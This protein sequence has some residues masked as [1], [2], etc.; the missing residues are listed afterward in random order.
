MG[1]FD[2]LFGQSSASAN[3][4]P[5]RFGRYTDSYK[6]EMQYQAWDR[7]LAAFERD[8]FMTSYRE[9]FVYL[10]DGA[11]NNVQ[12]KE[13]GNRIDFEILQ[14]SKKV[15]G[16]ATPERFKA[17]APVAKASALNIGFMRRMVEHNFDLKFG[18]YAL[19]PDN[20]V[21]LVFDTYS[22]DGSPFKLYYALKEIATHAD[23]QDDL[24]LDEF[25]ML[26]PI[27]TEH[28]DELPEVEKEAK[29]RF[30]RE[31][32]Q[33]TFEYIDSNH[34]DAIQYPGGIAYLLLHLCYKLDYLTKPEGFM[35]E[36]LER[37]HRNYF[38][39]D[40]RNMAQKN[41]FMRKEFQKLLDRPKS[42]FFKEMYKAPS[43]FGITTPVN[44]DKIIAFID[45]ELNN[46]DWYRDQKY[47]DVA[48]AIPGYIAGYSV[49]N[50]AGP[51]PVQ[52]M[53]HLFFQ[54]TEAAYFEQLGFTP[55]LFDKE[56]GAFDQRAIKRSLQ[57]IEESNREKFPKLDIDAGKLVFTNLP[58]FAKSYLL[59]IRN[60]KLA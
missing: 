3:Q 29:Y 42:D 60:L 24:L 41:Q 20:E 38:A 55:V 51:R 15:T 35:M 49:F 43:T 34:L 31:E 28:T 36:A 8:D 56:K 22:L 6:D 19:S 26:T 11:E 7:A 40:N 47:F 58:D 44:L 39:N 45:S 5:V 37:M 18:R 10:R 30:I 27:Q 54:V 2:R 23:K 46:M 9:F 52:Q 13:F 32:I 21:V 48:L 25:D 4:P 1:L 33:R 57:Q 53:F 14:G 12:T 59:L 50:Y 16:F 17:E